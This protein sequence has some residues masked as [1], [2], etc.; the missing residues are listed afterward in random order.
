MVEMKMEFG[1]RSMV[2][3]TKSYFSKSLGHRLPILR[4]SSPVSAVCNI[5]DRLMSRIPEA[6]Y[7]VSDGNLYKVEQVEASQLCLIRDMLEDVQEAHWVDYALGP[8]LDHMGKLFGITRRVD[9]SDSTLRLRI[10]TMIPTL[11]GGGTLESLARAIVPILGVSESDIVL[12]DGYLAG[13]SKGGNIFLLKLDGNGN[14]WE[15]NH[16]AIPQYIV[17]PYVT[18]RFDQAIKMLPNEYFIM[19]THSDY[20]TQSFQVGAWIKKTNANSSGVIIR[21]HNFDA[22]ITEWSLSCL[23]SGKL[24]AAVKTIDSLVVTLDSA[25]TLKTGE[26][27]FVAMSW[28]ET[29]KTLSL[30]Q[31]QDGKRGRVYYIDNESI[32][33]AVGARFFVG[34]DIEIGGSR[35]LGN[36]IMATLDHVYY[37]SHTANIKEIA[38]LAYCAPGLDHYGH[39]NLTIKGNVAGISNDQWNFAEGVVNKYKAAGI[40]FDGFGNKL[41]HNI[42]MDVDGMYW[43]YTD[44]SK[45][46]SLNK[47]KLA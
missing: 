18:G 27:Y 40:V 25:F 42:S 32:V 45:T 36:T 12:S 29:T 39:F 1:S 23:A 37:R 44:C 21:R 47:V 5:V 19:P 26:W 28:N 4:K 15:G 11:T 41:P 10:K 46:D 2:M 14:D 7:K 17:N 3:L 43:H 38:E 8:A 9:E 20:N 30:Y 22:N 13:D 33:G 6:Y 16:N 31:I 24:R 35:V 34:G